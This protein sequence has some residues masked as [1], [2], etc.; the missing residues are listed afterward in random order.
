MPASAAAAATE[1]LGLAW[2][3]LVGHLLHYGLIA[4]GLVGVVL[5]LAP[6]LVPGWRRGRG[7]RDAGARTGSPR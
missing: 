7:D 2:L 6:G 1:L 5:L 3:E 4:A